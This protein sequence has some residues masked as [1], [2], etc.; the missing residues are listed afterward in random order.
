M[1]YLYT[2]LGCQSRSPRAPTCTV[3]FSGESTPLPT[4]SHPDR[5]I[6]SPLYP[7]HRL[8]RQTSLYHILCQAVP[9]EADGC[10]VIMGGRS[11][12]WSLDLGMMTTTDFQSPPDKALNYQNPSNTVPTRHPKFLFFTLTGNKGTIILGDHMDEK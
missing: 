12:N 7:L 8:V 11:T 2:L 4:H 10:T 6:E 3:W 5:S 1:E 9:M